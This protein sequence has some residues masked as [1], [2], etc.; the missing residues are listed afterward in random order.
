MV[1]KFAR[2]GNLERGIHKVKE[3]EEEKNFE[4][5]YSRRTAGIA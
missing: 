2:N 5:L 1:Y 4:K 3:F